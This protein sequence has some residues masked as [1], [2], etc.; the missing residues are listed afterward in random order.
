[1][2]VHWN[3]HTSLYTDMHTYTAHTLEI[4]NNPLWSVGIA[5]SV[6]CL[7]YNHENM[8]LI[9]RTQVL[10]KSGHDSTGW[11][12]QH[13]E[14]ETGGFL[15]LPGHP[16]IQPSSNPNNPHPEFST[17][18]SSSQLCLLTDDVIGGDRRGPEN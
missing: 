15:G 10:K 12:T 18:K 6:K 2:H 17:G 14:L 13:R 4:K 9:P 5:Q 11:H 3:I 16:V 7:P 8:S 1:M